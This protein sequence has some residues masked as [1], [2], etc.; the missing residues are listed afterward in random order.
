MENRAVVGEQ[1]KQ[2]EWQWRD[3]R[4][5]ASD[6]GRDKEHGVSGGRREWTER[7]VVGETRKRTG[8]GW[9]GDQVLPGSLDMHHK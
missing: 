3:K 9:A 8:K 6:S 5:R 4:G 1:E 7:V 2:S